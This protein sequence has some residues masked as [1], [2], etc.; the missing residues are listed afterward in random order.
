MK[1]SLIKILEESL[2]A[3]NMTKERWGLIK[4]TRLLEAIE[5]KQ[6]VSYIGQLYGHS[7]AAIGLFLGINHSS[8]CTHKKNCLSFLEI[9]RVFSSKIKK[10]LESIKDNIE[11]IDEYSFNSFLRRDGDG[12]IYLSNGIPKEIFPQII[13]DNSPVECKVIIKLK[14]YERE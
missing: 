5:I 9:D 7:Q 12:V 8:V 3:F 1:P 13:E 10:A 2:S 14:K 6:S 4:N 11:D